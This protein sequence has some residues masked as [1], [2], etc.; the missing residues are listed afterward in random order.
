MPFPGNLLAGLKCAKYI[1]AHYPDVKIVMGGGYVN[2]ELRQ[3]RDT[4]IFKYVDYIT[5]DD[6][7]LPIRRLI[8][9]GELLRM[10][11][12]STA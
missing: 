11:Y 2:T 8:E 12:N 10:A 5:F 4:G 6:G 9:G 7:E 1:K 3:M